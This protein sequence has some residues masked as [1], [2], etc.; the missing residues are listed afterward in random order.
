M[1]LSIN[2]MCV[3]LYDQATTRDLLSESLPKRQWLSNVLDANYVLE[4]KKRQFISLPRYISGEFGLSPVI[5]THEYDIDSNA[6]SIACPAQ[7][8]SHMNISWTRWIY[9]F[10][11][12]YIHILNCI[13]TDDV[14]RHARL[15]KN[16]QMQFPVVSF[17]IRLCTSRILLYSTSRQ[18]TCAR[19]ELFHSSILYNYIDPLNT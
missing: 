12:A 4:A 3:S 5:H 19:F 8:R 11:Q 10:G 1:L 6:F 17:I 9:G 16:C 18:W 14:S 2:E 13:W 7:G 15:F